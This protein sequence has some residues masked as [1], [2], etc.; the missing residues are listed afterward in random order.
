MTTCFPQQLCPY[1]AL[2]LRYKRDIDQELPISTY[3]YL[4]IWPH[5]W[6]WSQWNFAEV[7]GIRKL[8]SLSYRTDC[9]LDPTFSR[10]GRAPT[11]DRVDRQTD[12]DGRIHD[13]SV[14]LYG[15]SIESRE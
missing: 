9:L 11:C 2:F 5:Y 13:H 4:Y 15:A 10:F 12:M 8:K 14:G 7:L 1:L 6:G 3:P